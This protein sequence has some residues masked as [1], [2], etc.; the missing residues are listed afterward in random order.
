MKSY[1]TGSAQLN[2]GPKHLNLMM[3]KVPSLKIGL[4]FEMIISPIEIQ[5]CSLLDINQKLKEARDILLPRLMNRT[6]E[7]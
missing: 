5:I 4:Q 7:V 3:L 6:I 2:F 1:A